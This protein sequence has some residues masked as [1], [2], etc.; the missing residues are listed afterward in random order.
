M[1]ERDDEVERLRARVNELEHQLDQAPATVP[2][3]VE[4]PTGRRAGWWRPATVTVL[5]VLVGLLAPLSV[6]AV[7]ARDVVG[8]TDRYVETVAPLADDPVI[9]SAVADRITLELMSRLD[10]EGITQEALSAL[11]DRGLPPRAAEGLAA[12]AP[13]LA[14]G[15]EGFVHEKVTDLVQSD[16][17]ATAWEEANRQAHTQMVA[18]LTG[19]GTETINVRG[20]T[21][22]VNLA[23]V[24]EAVK[25]RLVDAGFGLAARVPAV[26]AEFTIF[27]STD[28]VKAQNGFRILSA[29]AHVLPWLALLLLG[30]AVWVARDRR[31]ALLAGALVVAGSMVLLGAGINLARGIYINALS[32]Q[33]A[34]VPAAT[35]VYD[36]LVVFLRVGLRS[37][38]VLFLIVALIAW[39]SGSGSAPTSVRRGTATSIAALRGR[40]G[41]DTGRFGATLWQL[42]NPIRVA[43]LGG[44]FL[45]YVLAAHPTPA[46]TL[47]VAAIAGVVLLVVEFLASPPQTPEPAGPEA[48]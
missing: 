36:A 22:S 19:E 9:Q 30:A 46:F 18:V 3:E 45:V 48:G 20:G 26:Q 16:A 7:W 15:I 23:T 13:T 21:V 29:L 4:T 42:R 24:I 41:L 40:S 31:R 11:E 38:L 32:D 17:F 35:A 44:A 43:V 12:M 6:A 37:V 8:D 10:I 34:S 39:V 25:Q 2:L 33:V 28:L 1:T 47:T 27:E 14:N 5:L